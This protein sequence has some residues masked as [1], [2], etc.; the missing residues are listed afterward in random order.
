MSASALDSLRLLLGL[1]KHLEEGQGAV[2][3]VGRVVGLQLD[4]LA[5]VLHR[6]PVLLGLEGLVALRLGLRSLLCPGLGLAALLVVVLPLRL[7]CTS[8]QHW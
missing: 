1:A 4:G 7:L 6:L 2:I 8:R 5:V 3:V